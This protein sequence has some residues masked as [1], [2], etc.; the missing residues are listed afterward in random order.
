MT[1]VIEWLGFYTNANI[2]PPNAGQATEVREIISL[3]I[4]FVKILHPRS[5]LTPF[6]FALRQ[7]R[8]RWCYNRMA[9]GFCSKEIPSKA[10]AGPPTLKQKI[11]C[12]GHE[13]QFCG[14]VSMPFG[15]N[16]R[17]RSC[18]HKMKSINDSLPGLLI[19]LEDLKILQHQ[20]ELFTPAVL[21]LLSSCSGSEKQCSLDFLTASGRLPL[22]EV[23]THQKEISEGRLLDTCAA[24]QAQRLI[25]C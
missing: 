1:T 5:C 3:S 23:S 12:R 20:A 7:V 9:Y 16:V 19:A 18:S 11:G 8:D 14:L 21:S 25:R 22:G 4:V 17:E 13:N 10:L 15:A 2:S 24:I 6:H